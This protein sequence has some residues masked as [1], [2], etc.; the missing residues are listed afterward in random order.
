MSFESRPQLVLVKHCSHCRSQASFTEGMSD[1]TVG[2][3]S[4]SLFRSAGSC[5]RYGR[6]RGSLKKQEL[7]TQKPT[8]WSACSGLC[9]HTRTPSLFNQQT[10]Q[11]YTCLLG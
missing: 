4:P 10:N 9:L 7:A 11:H 8:E 5:P 1:G 2:H 3:L 6:K